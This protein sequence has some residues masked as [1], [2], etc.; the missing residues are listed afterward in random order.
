MLPSLSARALT[1]R[2]SSG[3]LSAGLV[4]STLAAPARSSAAGAFAAR[5][6][7]ANNERMQKR[8]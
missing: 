8:K 3:V 2:L 7:N 6:G 1:Y 4:M 5:V